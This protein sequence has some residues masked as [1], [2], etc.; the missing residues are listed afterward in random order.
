MTTYSNLSAGV[1]GFGSIG[2]RHID[3]LLN[4]G[5][6]TITLLR[7]R[8]SKSH[9]GFLEVNN[10]EDFVGSG[11]DFVIISNPTALHYEFLSKLLNLNCNIFCE[12]P[13]VANLIEAISVKESLTLYSGI[14]A[15]AF[16]M[17]FHP[18][19]IRLK[20]ILE[21]NIFGKVLHARLFVGQYL[22]DWRPNIDYSE[23][24]SA[25]RE[26]GGGVT[27][28]LVHEI[29][30]AIFLFGKP[31]NE[32]KSISGKYSNLKINTEDITEIIYK[33]KSGN[34][35]SIHLDY[36]YRGYKRKIEIITEKCNINCDLFKNEISIIDE[37]GLT[38]EVYNFEEFNRNDMYYDLIKS[39]L[40][41]I[42]LKKE[43]TPNLKDGLESNLIALDVLKTNGI[44]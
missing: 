19:I 4:L 21:S 5:L 38:I 17:R 39:Y 15:T 2:K 42:Q 26:L 36:I 44:I 35:I 25:I 33:S 23:S 34:L 7:V 1:I 28:D 31:D 37:K 8:N 32:F 20:D 41:S 40:D 10:F 6:N 3:N 30:L 12:K 9:S 16:N 14:S 27:L 22:P 18:V 13:L 24:Y 29:D 43:F 11:L